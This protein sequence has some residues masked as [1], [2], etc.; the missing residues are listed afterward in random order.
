MNLLRSPLRFLPCL[1]ALLLAF[2]LAGRASAQVDINSADARTLA[3]ALAGV[4]LV[5]AE[6][7]VAYRDSN[8]PF[9]QPEDL[10]KVKGIGHKT[11]DANR[12]AIVVVPPRNASA[13]G[14]GERAVTPS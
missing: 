4:G 7:I 14:G 10:L 13:R 2:G 8:G 9:V 3:S 12:A 5:K 6:A 11:L 1:F